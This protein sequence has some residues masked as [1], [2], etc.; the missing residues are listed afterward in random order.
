MSGLILAVLIGIIV[1][2]LWRRFGK[3]L[4]L[5]GGNKN[6]WAIVII[7]VVLLMIFYGGTHTPH[8]PVK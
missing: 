3:K 4:H 5:P 1:A 6:L 2:V 7:V 8:T